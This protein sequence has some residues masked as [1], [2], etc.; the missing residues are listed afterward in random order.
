MNDYNSYAVCTI[1]SSGSGINEKM[2]DFREVVFL[3]CKEQR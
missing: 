3:N 2:L 1:K